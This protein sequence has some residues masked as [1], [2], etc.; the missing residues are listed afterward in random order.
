MLNNQPLKTLETLVNTRKGGVYNIRGIVYQAVYTVYRLVYEFSSDVNDNSVFQLEGVEDL[1]FYRLHN[2]SSGEFIQLKC[3]NENLNTS[4]FTHNILRNLLEV[5]I[6]EPNARFTIVSNVHLDKTLSELKSL[7]YGKPL[8]DKGLLFWQ[9]KI[10]ILGYSFEE[11]TVRHFLDTIH[12]E[13]K[14]QDELLSEIQ[15]LLILKFEVVNDNDIRFTQAL[16]YAVLEW[17]KQKAF[18]H[19]KDVYAIIQAVYDDM[20]KGV[21]NNA[22]QGGWF[23]QVSFDTIIDDISA[24]GYFEGKAA[25]PIHIAANLPIKR[26][27]WENE[28]LDAILNFDVTVIKASSGQG[29]STLAWQVANA[30]LQQNYVVYELNEIGVNGVNDAFTF[31]QSRLRVG[32]LPLIVIDGLNDTVKDWAILAE[33]SQILSCFQLDE[34][35]GIKG[36]KFLITTREEDWFRYGKQGISRLN[37]KA[38]NIKLSENEAQNIFTAFKK[39][40]KLHVN[41]TL[42]QVAWEKVRD[43]KLLIE[44]VYL[45]TQGNMIHERMEEQIYG[46]ESDADSSAK[47]LILRLVTVADMLNIKLNTKKLLRFVEQ[48][49]S[50]KNDRGIVLNSLK[51]EYHI[52]LEENYWVVGLHPIRSTHIAHILHQA[53]PY[54]ETLIQLIS[55]IDDSKMFT[56]IS[57]IPQLPMSVNDRQSFFEDLANTVSIHPYSTIVETV[58]GVY[59]L[60]AHQHWLENKDV[61]DKISNQGLM[62]YINKSPFSQLQSN[63]FDFLIEYAPHMGENF[64]AIKDFN[65]HQSNTLYFLKQLNVVLQTKSVKEDLSKAGYLQRWFQRYDLKASILRGVSVTDL[66]Q[67]LIEKPVI[68]LSEILHSVYN[69]NKN[70]YDSFYRVN[71]DKLL[72]KLQIETNT[73]TAFLKD[74]TI[75]LRYIVNN[76]QDIKKQSVNRAEVFAYCLP[77]IENLDIAGLYFPTP[78][79]LNYLKHDDSILKTSQTGWLTFDNFVTKANQAWLNTI[80]QVYEFETQYEWE[81]YWVEYRRKLLNWTQQTC[82]VLEC[83][84]DLKKLNPELNLWEK[85]RIELSNHKRKEKS[86]RYDD[87]YFPKSVIVDE[88]SKI[89]DWNSAA[90]N[91]LIQTFPDFKEAHKWHLYKLN[92]RS[93]ATKIDKMQIA[94]DTICQKT[95]HFFDVNDLKNQEETTFTYLADLIEYVYDEVYIKKIPIINI[96]QDVKKWK[97]QKHQKLIAQLHEVKETFETAT[98]FELVLPQNILYEGDFLTSIVLGIRDITPQDFDLFADS[99]LHGLFGLAEIQVTYFY[100]VLIDNQNTALSNGIKFSHDTLLGIIDVFYGRKT[101]V[102]DSVLPIPLSEVH[103]NQLTVIKQIQNPP[104]DIIKNSIIAMHNSLWQ[105]TEIRNQLTNSEKDCQIWKQKLLTNHHEALM[106]QLTLLKNEP[107]IHQKYKDII[108]QVYDSRLDFNKEACNQYWQEDML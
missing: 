15:K 19:K 20:S 88:T 31:I 80:E 32:I 44:Y 93:A 3:L 79:I 25:K 16:F 42:W 4:Q 41:V 83:V 39:Q 87:E 8:S 21:I 46:L 73:I 77:H 28:I 68:E 103:I 18:V 54:S 1:D 85:S 101:S 17:S 24:N 99:I 66:E 37:L 7:K 35:T 13:R 48:N 96:R 51:S 62:L 55:I 12:F 36:V 97:K 105:F 86:L 33:K 60:D 82:R 108:Q 5:Y 75:V 11:S 14:T 61:Y 74:N 70:V 52:Q 69:I 57:Q 2:S 90:E 107:A 78:L 9:E 23:T 102:N 10:R 94:F 89:R 95:A 98:I 26:S 81:N 56:L 72:S 92:T 91:V 30:L 27:K 59:A 71:K 47:M 100:L 65:I 63:S 67:A 43:K 40:G 106:L 50:F 58:N 34:A 49:R 64:A 104:S 38:V 84:S 29:K 45:L 6:K 22:I 76:D 53:L